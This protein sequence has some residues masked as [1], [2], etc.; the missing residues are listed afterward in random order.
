MGQVT[1]V[2]LLPRASCQVNLSTVDKQNEVY[3]VHFF[4]RDLPGAD[5]FHGKAIH[6]TRF[7]TRSSKHPDPRLINWHYRQCVMARIRGF[8]S[9]MEIAAT[10]AAA[11][12]QFH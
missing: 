5:D 1:T 12:E 11:M 4:D 6:S 2:I 9:G 3:Y 8:A 10:S 7:H